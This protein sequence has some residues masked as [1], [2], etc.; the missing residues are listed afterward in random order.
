[1]G[2][3]IICGKDSGKG[4]TCSSTCRSRLARSVAKNSKLSP[5]T[6]AVVAVALEKEPSVATVKRGVDIKTFEDL[7]PDVQRTIEAMSQH[8]DN[9]AEDKAKR[10]ARAIAY[11]HLFP[12]R[13]E[14]TG[15]C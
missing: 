4:R 1:M 3:C 10:T 7:P 5:A 2:K 9:K 14:T 11:Q 12:D 8:A 13:Y 15:L 6:V